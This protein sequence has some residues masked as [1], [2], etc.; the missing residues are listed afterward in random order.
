MNITKLLT[1]VLDSSHNFRKISQ[2]FIKVKYANL[3]AT[4]IV[5]PDLVLC[6]DS[7]L[8]DEYWVTFLD[9][10][11]G[12]VF[13]E[14]GLDNWIPFMVLFHEHFQTAERYTKHLSKLHRIY[15][16]LLCMEHTW[17][18]S[19]DITKLVDLGIISTYTFDL[20]LSLG[21]LVLDVLL[22]ELLP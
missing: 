14:R 1:T 5:Y 21:L 22:R 9:L 16:V 12:D 17:L 13:M 6:L 15:S 19:L 18:G 3:P 11:E 7:R 4:L 2:R 10:D 20:D 8:I